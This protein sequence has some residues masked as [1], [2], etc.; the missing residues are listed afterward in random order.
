MNISSARKPMPEAT[1]DQEAAFEADLMRQAQANR[2]DFAPLYER[3]VDRI[4]AYCSGRTNTPEEAEDLCSQVFAR[5]LSR[6]DTYRGGMVGAWLFRI[7]HNLIVDHYRKR[8]PLVSLDMVDL[9]EDD[10]LNSAEEIEQGEMIR[11]LVAELP[12][13]KRSLLALS[14]DSDLSSE[15]VGVIVGKS[16]GAVR[17][18]IHRLIKQMRKRFEELSGDTN[19]GESAR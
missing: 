17:V 13:D 3:Y 9:M 1:D 12:E 8:R 18:E 14:L 19:S 11:R 4:Y 2:E 5:A 6:I 15:D 7:A 10:P 16:A